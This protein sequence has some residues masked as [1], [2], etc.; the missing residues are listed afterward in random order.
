VPRSKADETYSDPLGLDD[1]LPDDDP[2]CAPQAPLV[3]TG[4]SD[5]EDAGRHLALRF[6]PE[7]RF[8]PNCETFHGPPVKGKHDH[9]CSYCGD[10][11][12]PMG[13]KP[14]TKKIPQQ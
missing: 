3:I 8:C 9:W 4:L 13:T 5:E 12:R 1:P 14:R 10:N 2:I 7:L 11:L 6:N